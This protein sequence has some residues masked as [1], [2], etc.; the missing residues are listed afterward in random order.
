MNEHNAISTNPVVTQQPLLQQLKLN[1][2]PS[3]QQITTVQIN[4][5]IVP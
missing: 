2:Y 5:F 3:N 1:K 4:Q